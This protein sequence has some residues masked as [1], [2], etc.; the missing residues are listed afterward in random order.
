MCTGIETA[1]LIASLA[2][3]IASITTSSVIA[4]EQADAQ[5]KLANEQANF[6]R[7]Q[8]VKAQQEAAEAAA[9]ERVALAEEAARARGRAQNV[10]LGGASLRAFLV[11][12][13]RRQ[14][15]SD[16]IIGRNLDLANERAQAQARGVE[17]ERAARMLD[18]DAGRPNAAVVGLGLAGTVAGGGLRIY[19]AYNAEQTGVLPVR[20]GATV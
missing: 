9:E 10:G 15:R 1:L 12:I 19:N 16:A 13:S 5:E 7:Q 3:S 6:E 2:V 17:L 8:A 4:S 14:G 11:D 20:S 18:I